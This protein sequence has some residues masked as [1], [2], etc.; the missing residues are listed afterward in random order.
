VALVSG[1]SL[2]RLGLSLLDP[3]SKL[4][5]PLPL[6]QTPTTLALLLLP[7][8]CLHHLGYHLGIFRLPHL[9]IA[10]LLCY[11]FLHP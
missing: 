9:V 2:A 8:C 7:L 6:H 3:T 11:K 5:V 10:T 1:A 4:Q